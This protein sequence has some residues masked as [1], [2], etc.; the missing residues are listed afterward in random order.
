MAETLKLSLA[1]EGSSADNHLINMYDGAKAIA[2]FQRSLAITTHLI[3]NGEIITQAPS[4]NG[5]TI[6]MPPSQQGSWKTNVLIVVGGI[7]TLSIAA[8]TASTDS[9]YGHLIASAYAWVTNEALGFEADYDDTLQKQIYEYNETHEKKLDESRLDAVVE[10]TENSIIDMHRPI[11][12][13]KTAV[14]A[15]IKKEDDVKLEYDFPIINKESYDYISYTETSKVPKTLIA[16][17][18]SYNLNTYRGRAYFPDLGNR[19]ISFSLAEQCRTISNVLKLTNSLTKTAESSGTEGHI[20]LT[21]LRNESST[22]RI[23]SI[24]VI[25]VINVTQYEQSLSHLN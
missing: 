16:R 17:V 1:Y 15:L 11:V 6:L 22:G 24:Y 20:Y 23:K 7:G 5:A 2:G 19:T 8:G 13:S 21:F 4:L 25:N 10:K 18:T 9:L 3:L 12:K 14:R